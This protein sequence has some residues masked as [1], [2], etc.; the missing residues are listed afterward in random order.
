MDDRNARHEQG[1]SHD[2]VVKRIVERIAF[3]LASPY[4]TISKESVLIAP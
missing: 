4:P 3:H 1:D 2:G